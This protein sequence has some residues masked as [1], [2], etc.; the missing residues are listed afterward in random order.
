MLE[1]YIDVDTTLSSEAGA[2]HKSCRLPKLAGHVA[3]ALHFLEN[4]GSIQHRYQS[5]YSRIYGQGVCTSANAG[6]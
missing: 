4:F 3:R 5:D 2:L 1:P 6:S